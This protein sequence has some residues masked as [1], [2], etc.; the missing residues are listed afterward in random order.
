MNIKILT[1]ADLHGASDFYDIDSLESVCSESDI[2]VSLG[3]NRQNDIQFIEELA[4]IHNKPLYGVLGNHDLVE[5]FN[6]DIFNDVNGV[7]DEINL[8]KDYTIT[9]MEGSL[10]T[11]RFRDSY[12]NQ[13]DS[14]EYA[15]TLKPAHILLSHDGPYRD[16]FGGL[17]GVKQYILNNKPV[18]S[19]HGHQHFNDMWYLGKTAVICCKGIVYI[20]VKDNN[21]DVDVIEE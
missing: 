17:K 7:L 1:F 12:A 19:L 18:L 5:W 14:V 8:D 15:S 6:S 11:E 13:Q 16:G 9:G 2:I 3:D 4:E 20:D 21:V 10:S